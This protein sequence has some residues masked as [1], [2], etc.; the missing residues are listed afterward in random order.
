M[1]YLKHVGR[2]MRVVVPGRRHEWTA[3]YIRTQMSAV[4]LAI[5]RAWLK[6]ESLA[7]PSQALTSPAL[8][9]GLCKTRAQALS[10]VESIVQSRSYT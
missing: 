4:R 6:P 7:R 10:S 3:P 2:G 5:Y 8:E 9:E 1:F